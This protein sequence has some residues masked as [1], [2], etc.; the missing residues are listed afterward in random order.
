MIS[1]L[2]PC[3]GRYNGTSAYFASEAVL[4]AMYFIITF[5]VLLSFIFPV[6]NCSLMDGIYFKRVLNILL[7]YRDIFV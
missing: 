2:A 1:M 4:T 7:M 3:S 6:H 5:L